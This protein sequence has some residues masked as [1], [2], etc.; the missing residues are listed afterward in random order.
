MIYLY[1]YKPTKARYKSGRYKMYS[2]CAFCRYGINRR[3][4]VVC[5]LFGAD[6]LRNCSKYVPKEP[7][8]VPMI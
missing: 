7:I 3:G 4:K 2:K 5:S 6:K 8:V 1:S